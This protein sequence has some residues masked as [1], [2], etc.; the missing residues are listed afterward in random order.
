MATRFNF[1]MSIGL[2]AGF[3]QPAHGNV[4]KFCIIS[5]ATGQLSSVTP[6]SFIILFVTCFSQ[7]SRKLKREARDFSALKRVILNTAGRRESGKN[8]VDPVF[9]FRDILL[10]EARGYEV[11]IFVLN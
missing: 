1:Q 9:V 3:M 6:C 5:T 7:P 4:A 11:N 8:V 2:L 10:H